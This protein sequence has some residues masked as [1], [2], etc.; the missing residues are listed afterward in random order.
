MTYPTS[1]TPALTGPEAIHA[2]ALAA[3]LASID[4]L[5]RQEI[6]EGETTEDDLAPLVAAKA[7]LL[8]WAQTEATEYGGDDATNQP[9]MAS[10]EL[11]LTRKSDGLI[12]KSFDTGVTA[13]PEGTFSAI[14]NTGNVLD[15]QSD[16]MLENCW[17]DVISKMR[18]GQVAW[19]ALCWNHKWDEPIGRITYAEELA[20]GDPRIKS[21]DPKATGLLIHGKFNMRTSRGKD[22]FEDVRFGSIR[23]M[24]VGFIAAEGGESFNSKGQ[25]L[26]SKVGRWPECSFVLVGASP[27]TGILAGTLKTIS[28]PEATVAVADLPKG[29]QDLIHDLV[30]E[31]LTHAE[32][33]SSEDK[34][35]LTKWIRVALEDLEA[36]AESPQSPGHHRRIFKH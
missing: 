13:E 8:T 22:A 2:D 3:A 30:E 9:V 19:P 15:Y 16:V 20:A 10:A 24:S 28:T 18:T 27:D 31:E 5:V 4:Q 12:Y 1:D 35:L 14:A 33:M 23:E 34:N 17:S 32:P 26:V 21:A 11:D 36:E 6:D 25:R 29:L 7:A